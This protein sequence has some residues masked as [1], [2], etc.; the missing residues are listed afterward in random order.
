MDSTSK[1]ALGL[2]LRA[3]RDSGLIYVIHEVKQPC[4]HITIRPPSKKI[5]PEKVAQ[6]PQ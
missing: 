4:F 2:T 1:Q 5:I 3:L 6:S